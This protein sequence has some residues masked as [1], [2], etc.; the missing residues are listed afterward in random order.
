MFGW[1]DLTDAERTTIS[2]G[3]AV[4]RF[5]FRDGRSGPD[6]IFNGGFALRGQ[7]ADL[8]AHAYGNNLR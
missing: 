4:S 1:R 5:T 2:E 7:S 6:V 3:G 8:L